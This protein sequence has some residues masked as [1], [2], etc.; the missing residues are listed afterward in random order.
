MVLW[1]QPN[2]TFVKIIDFVI[3]FENQKMSFG[4]HQ[5][6]TCENSYKMTTLE[7]M[8]CFWPNDKLVKIIDFV[9]VIEC[10]KSFGFDEVL[11]TDHNNKEAVWARR[12]FTETK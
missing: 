2:N 8:L 5:S 1:C 6:T 12:R 11:E 4:P 10:E 3:I 7:M 9:K